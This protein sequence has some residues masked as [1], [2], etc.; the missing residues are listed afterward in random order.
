M[1]TSDQ[2]R[3]QLPPPAPDDPLYRRMC[4]C[5]GRVRSWMEPYCVCGN[6]EFSIDPRA[7]EAE[8]N[9]GKVAS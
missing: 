3:A 2:R 8:D 5:C 1:S 9:N 4:T 6:P 7:L